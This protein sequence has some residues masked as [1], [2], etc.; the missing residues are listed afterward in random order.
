MKDVLQIFCKNNGTVIE[1]KPGSSLVEIYQKS[2]LALPYGPTSAKVNNV[3]VGLNFRIYRPMDV[4]FLDISSGSGL[5]AYVRSL[6][7][8]LCKAV[9][10][11]YPEGQIVLQHP[12]SHGHY[13]TLKIGHTPTTDE[14]GHIRQRM[15]EII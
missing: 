4:E 10:D 1:A 11:I 2:G 13:C 12:V 8:V 14:V 6:C 7:F 9:A 15:A 5:R 3:S